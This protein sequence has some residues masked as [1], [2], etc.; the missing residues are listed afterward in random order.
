MKGDAEPITLWHCLNCGMPSDTPTR[1]HIC[2]HGRE[3][4]ALSLDDGGAAEEQ[5]RLDRENPWDSEA[6]NTI[7]RSLRV[8]RRW[9]DE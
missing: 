6:E 8:G 7:T 9:E 1:C 2:G 3:D 5:L 4:N